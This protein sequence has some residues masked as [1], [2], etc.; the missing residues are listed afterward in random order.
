MWFDRE[1]EGCSQVPFFISLQVC[2]FTTA[3]QGRPQAA[4]LPATAQPH[5]HINE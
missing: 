3:G 1:R 4:P 5:P 2:T